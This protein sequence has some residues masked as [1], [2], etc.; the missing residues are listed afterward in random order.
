LRRHMKLK[1]IEREPENT[2]AAA[3]AGSGQPN[4][5]TD[6]QVAALR[7]LL[8]ALMVELG[9]LDKHSITLEALKAE[10]QAVLGAS[11]GVH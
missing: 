5:S 11:D 4:L 7:T 10:I 1:T 8:L 3:I 6:T 9:L 2:Y